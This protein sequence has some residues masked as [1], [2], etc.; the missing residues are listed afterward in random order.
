[1]SAHLARAKRVAAFDPDIWYT[2]G[3]VAADQGDWSSALADWRESLVR[4]PKWL[5]VIARRAATHFTP[6]ELRTRLLPDDP[7]VW[8]AA[9]RFVF[10]DP[11]DLARVAWLRV[12]ANRW[13]AGPEPAALAGFVAWATTLEELDDGTAALRVWRRAVERFPE[14]TTPRDRL[15]T[16][17]EAEELYEEAAPVLEWLAARHPKN[18]DYGHRLEAARHAIKLKA[19]IDRK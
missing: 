15:A 19:D 8:F 17:L 3:R 13:E 12:T 7:A 10:P 9:T 1:V 5:G 2:S 14:E 4:S 18:S 16:R 11:D 6:D